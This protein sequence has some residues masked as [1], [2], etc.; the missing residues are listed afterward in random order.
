MKKDIEIFLESDLLEKY[1]IGSTTEK[2]AIQVEHYIS[3]YPEVRTTYDELQDNLENYARSFAIKAPVELKEQILND[4][5]KD[6]HNSTYRVP[7]YY[8][9]ASVAAILFCTSSIFLWSRNSMLSKENS[10]VSSELMDLKNDILVTN[11]KLEDIKN[12]FVVLNNPET[13]KYVLRGNQRANNLKTVA[14]INPVEK[15]SLINVVSLP[16]LPE[17]QVYQMWADVN[18]EMVSLGILKRNEN[19]LLSIPFKENASSYNITIEPKGGNIE[20]TVDNIV[21]NIPIK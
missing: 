9:A 17:E 4:I 18:G 7:W 20:A 8:V 21:A 16:D 10:I 14:Y 15:L 1:L 3:K 11:T 5:P 13:R 6:H 12:Q 2:E 19:E